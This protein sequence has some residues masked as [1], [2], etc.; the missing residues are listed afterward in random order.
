[1]YNYDTMTKE[2]F[3][4]I[5]D[6]IHGARYRYGLVDSI[7]S[8]LVIKVLCSVHGYFET[9]PQEHLEQ[10]GCKECVWMRD[11]IKA[12]QFVT[13]VGEY[14]DTLIRDNK[15]KFGEDF[16]PFGFLFTIK[17]P[18]ESILL[19]KEYHTVDVYI[20]G[21]LK[22]TGSM[23]LCRFIGDSQKF[24]TIKTKH[25]LIPMSVSMVNSE[26]FTGLIIRG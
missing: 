25:G 14:Q 7:K 15:K 6:R 11:Y 3:I 10:T 26:D 8:N 23:Q 13:V 4:E 24:L 20:D 9:T 16:D 18:M 5:A 1:M 2:E 22:G 12:E 17:G 21:V 19:L